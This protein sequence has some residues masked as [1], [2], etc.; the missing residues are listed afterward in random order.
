MSQTERRVLIAGASGETGKEL[1]SVLRPT[2]M[3]IRAMTRSY[4]AVDSLERLGADEV[5][6]G[7]LFDSADAVRA[8]D[9]CDIV[10]CA[11][12]TPPSIRHTIGGKLVDRTGVMN[13]ITAGIAFDIEHVVLQSAIGVGRSKAGMP[14][15][16][17]LLLH[18]S[19]RAK[20]DAET[21][22]R[23]SGLG[24]T[25]IRPG[26]LTDG[27]PRGDVLV[28]E[29]GDSVSGSISRADVAQLMATAPFTPDVRNRTLEVVTRDG[30]R[31]TPTN[32][33]EV[34]W[35][36]ELIGLDRG[37]IQSASQSST[38]SRFQS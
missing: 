5:I 14:L 37:S 32:L 27:P 13:L 2:E 6:V 3:T 22:L 11:V 17:R 24:Y 18:G 26:R 15:P 7:D 1:L 4:A 31:G 38:G 33:I 30:V 36:A 10:Y 20:R 28:G 8:V 25:I 9:G 21:A 29:G 12:G 34:E 23:R 35:N 16:G 19:L